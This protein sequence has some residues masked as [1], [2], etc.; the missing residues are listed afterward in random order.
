M[1]W[2]DAKVKKI[3]KSC[4]KANT[5]SIDKEYA[6]ALKKISFDLS[7]KPLSRMAKG[8]MIYIQLTKKTTLDE[9]SRIGKQ[10][11]KNVYDRGYVVH[12]CNMKNSNKRRKW[13]V[14]YAY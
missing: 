4:L 12:A 10:V 11:C 6:M 9:V 7:L 1:N 5:V 2:D 13:S 14:V 3:V 8:A